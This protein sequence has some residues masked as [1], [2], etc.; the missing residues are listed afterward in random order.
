MKLGDAF[1]MA[2]PPKYDIPHLFFVISDPAK[3]NGTFVIVNLTSD[4]FRAGKECTLNIG[5]HPRI[6]KESFISFADALEITPASAENLRK[7]IGKQITM[8]KGLAPNVLAKIVGA[9]KISKAMPV[10]LKKYL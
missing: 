9:A 8:Q 2:V 1:L 7:L 10:A 4:V 5:D 3:H 6:T